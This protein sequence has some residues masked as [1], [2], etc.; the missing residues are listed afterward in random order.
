MAIEITGKA[1]IKD[2]DPTNHKYS[3][4]IDCRRAEEIVVYLD[5]SN[6][7]EETE[8]KITPKVINKNLLNHGTDRFGLAILKGNNPITKENYVMKLEL[9]NKFRDSFP[10]SWNEDEF[11]LEV[12]F[13][14]ISPSGSEGNL[15]VGLDINALQ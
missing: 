14:G 11:I 10:V 15:L 6:A 7:G 1:Y 13:V 2:S 4:G 5:Y 12:E 3:I 9:G 8:L